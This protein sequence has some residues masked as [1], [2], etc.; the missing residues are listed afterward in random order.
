MIKSGYK[1]PSKSK[2]FV[3]GV[4]Q[5]FIPLPGSFCCWLKSAIPTPI[6]DSEHCTSG[7]VHRE[8][9]KHPPS[10]MRSAVPLGGLGTGS[11]ELRAD[12]TIHEWT[13][14]NQSPGGSAK[15][16][17]GALNL[18][19]FGVR[20]A[21]PDKNKSEAAL[22]RIHAPHGYPGVE[23]LSYS[24][25]FPVSKLTP[26][27]KKIYL[28]YLTN[29]EALAVYYTVIKHDGHLRTPGKC[30]KHKPQV[31]VSTFLECFQVTGVL[32]HSVIHGFGFFTCFKI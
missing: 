25:S 19:V 14:E 21:E 20:V 31:S 10:G 32:Y 18:A 24:G 22:L 26:G 23:S 27:K 4:S 9:T 2:V 7:I 3:Y 30:T 6:R 12:G 15:L 16:N 1:D 8:S 13:I 17:K 5:G 11:F 29:K 28:M